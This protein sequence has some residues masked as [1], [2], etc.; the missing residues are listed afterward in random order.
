M[1]SPRRRGRYG[2]GKEAAPRAL[3]A[4]CGMQKFD[5]AALQAA[6]DRKA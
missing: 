5:L 3:D 4:R 2:D 1:N 6:F